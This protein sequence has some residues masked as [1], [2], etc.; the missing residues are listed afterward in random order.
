M[1]MHVVKYLLA[2]LQCVISQNLSNNVQYVTKVERSILLT[3]ITRKNSPLPPPQCESGQSF[4]ENP[5]SYPEEHFLQ[6]IIENFSE[7]ERLTLLANNIRY[8]VNEPEKHK[9]WKTPKVPYGHRQV[10]KVKP[11][12]SKIVYE[13]HD[14]FEER[15]VCDSRTSFVY[16]KA[17][18]NNKMQ[19]RY[20]FNLGN[21]SRVSRDNVQVVKV[22]TC[23]GEGE[24]C[25]IL[26]YQ[27]RTVCRQKMWN[28][29]WWLW[30]LMDQNML[31]LSSS[32]LV[33]CAIKLL[34]Y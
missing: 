3:N 2:I 31:T 16:P 6:R 22:E 27:E 23:L 33:V 7:V 21:S 19:W 17:A 11:S 12:G 5:L 26:T 1:T 4:C 14:W 13:D 28:I 30:T 20:I 24:Q 10:S 8:E 34:L 9:T 29:G 18:I 15:P 32:P 25:N